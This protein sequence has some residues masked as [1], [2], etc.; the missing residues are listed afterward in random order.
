MKGVAS[1]ITAAKITPSASANN[2][3]WKTSSLARSR[4][5]APRDRATAEDTPA[6]I[7]LLVVCR[8]SITNGNARGGPGQRWGT[9]AAE[10][11]PVKNNHAK[12]GEEVQQ[13][14][15]GEP[16]QRRQDRP[17]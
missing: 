7:P 17:V 6:P 16:Q 12:K 9:D 13:V 15:C 4:F 10:K 8:T 11:N 5:P 14:G 2:R 1:S 3:A